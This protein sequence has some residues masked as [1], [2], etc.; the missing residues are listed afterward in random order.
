MQYFLCCCAKSIS[1]PERDQQLLQVHLRRLQLYEAS[2]HQIPCLL[3]CPFMN[4]RCDLEILLLPQTAETHF[5]SNQRRP[6]AVG[7]HQAALKL[8][9]RVVSCRSRREQLTSG[10]RWRFGGLPSAPFPGQDTNVTS[11]SQTGSFLTPTGLLTPLSLG[12]DGPVSTGGFLRAVISSFSLAS[13]LLPFLHSSS[14]HG[15]ILAFRRQ[16]DQYEEHEYEQYAEY[17][18]LDAVVITI[19][20]E[21]EKAYSSRGRISRE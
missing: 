19:D 16:Y 13:A 21:P 18:H 7:V 1:L 9:A 15:K 8:I 12:D 17:V 5:Q 14:V 4:D 2:E 6:L 10:R 11:R 3:L 20:K